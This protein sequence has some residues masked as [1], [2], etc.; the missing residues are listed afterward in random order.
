MQAERDH[1]RTRVFPEL[2]ERLHARRYHVEWVDL[3]MGAAIAANADE[4]ARELQVLKV[5]LGEVRRCRPFLIVLLGDRY[6]WIPPPDRIAAAATEEGFHADVAGRSVTELEIEFGVLADLDRQCRSMFYFR[7][8]LPYQEIPKAIAALYSEEF[9]FDEAAKER[10]LRLANLKRRIEDALPARVRRY[11]AEWDRERQRITGLDS[12]GRTVLDDIW[13]ELRVETAPLAKEISWQQVERNALD[14]F[15]EDHSRDFVGRQQVLVDLTRHALSPTADSAPWG[16]CVTGDAGSGKSALFAALHQQLKTLDVIVLAHAAGAGSRAAS[17]DAMLRRWAEDLATALGVDAGVAEN[18][19]EPEV[20]DTFYS[21]LERAARHRR[22]VVLVD[23]LDEFETT[24]RGRY[25]TWLLS[26]LW[27]ANARLIATTIAGEAS[28]NLAERPRLQVMG[29]SSLTIDEARGIVARRCARYHRT[30]EPSVVD[31]L[32]QKSGA[33]GPAWGN[34]LWLVLAVEELN[35]LDAD[36]FA[37][38]TRSYQ[39]APAEQLRALMVDFV[40]ALPANIVGLY[41]STFVRSEELFGANLAQAFLQLIAVSRSGWREGDF[42][43]LLPRL[44]GEPWDELRF[45]ALRRLFRGQIRRHGALAQ[46]T[47]GHRPMREAVLARAGWQGNTG[48]LHASISDHLLACRSDDPLRESE[49]MVHLLGSEDWARA[50]GYFGDAS[51]TDAE[52]DGATQVLLDAVLTA[53][54][55]RAI[56]AASRLTRLLDASCLD[57]TADGRC[58][59]RFISVIGTLLPH[60]SL[61]L[62]SIVA[63]A[64]RTKLERLIR[65]NP[66]HP[67]WRRHLALATMMLGDISAADGKSAAALTA[68][69]TSL[70]MLTGLRI[71]EADAEKQHLLC[72]AHLNI[73]DMLLMVGRREEALSEYRTSLTI[74]E[75]LVCAASEIPPVLRCYHKVGEVLAA[76]GQRSEA[77]TMYQKS[78]EIAERLAAADPHNASFRNAEADSCDRLGQMLAASGR[79]DEALRVYCRAWAIRDAAV[80][81]DPGNIWRLHDLSL[82]YI[83]V[84]D[85]QVAT[86]PEAALAA[87]QKSVSIR[88]KLV[89]TDP[90]NLRLQGDLARLYEKVAHAFQLLGELDAACVASQ[91]ALTIWKTLVTTDPSNARL[92][93]DLSTSHSNVADVLAV[94][95]RAAEATAEYRQGLAILEKLAG[96]DPGNTE[97]QR[98]LFVAYG[99]IGTILAL[100]GDHEQALTAHQQALAFSRK[101]ADLDPGNAEWQ[102]DLAFAHAY[103][104]DA[105]TAIGRRDDAF[106]TYRK[107]LEILERLEAVV[108]VPGWQS[109]LAEGY[110]KV[111]DGFA[112]LGRGDEALTVYEKSLSIHA[113][114]ASAQP[115]NLQSQRSLASCHAKIGD[116]L[117]AAHRSE[118]ALAAYQKNLTIRDQ[119]AG[120]T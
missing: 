66:D 75:K 95:G 90:R 77:L 44:T 7:A 120:R 113:N 30:L 96:D 52:I 112:A 47:F 5:C 32:M 108:G 1:L 81:A 10:M 92:Q 29:L 115:E 72:I 31:A 27:P 102:R 20:E 36:D 53:P 103:V 50:A 70:E 19:G 37:R 2:E 9:S 67:E 43:T 78:L 116:V 54:D 82:A 42:R 61:E 38:A 49:T 51:L 88:E 55:D 119:I 114:L 23:A 33:Q 56:A 4:A 97:F 86:D 76:A 65:S 110:D 39:G 107:S 104:G 45:A 118:D 101:L 13:A 48:P 41:E 60:V 46:W 74:A 69:Q 98:G 68:Y 91:T 106:A 58:A 16:I 22:V 105:L 63:E 64:A 18:D 100:I 109:E 59:E 28:K 80:V 83:R 84:A 111:G 21:L 3:R 34:A 12:F 89:A 85:L 6:G 25:A 99:R 24:T 35:L 117:L 87:Y 94:T 57:I 11:T 26:H 62:R 15:V 8:P 93:R 71:M 14:D 79:R 17:V 40:A 73:G